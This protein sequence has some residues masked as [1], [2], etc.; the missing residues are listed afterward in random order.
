MPIR[1]RP[2]G[3]VEIQAVKTPEPERVGIERRM[4]A[5][6]D[7]QRREAARGKGRGDR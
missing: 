3:A 4:L 7:Q 6:E 2:S 5:G 1:I